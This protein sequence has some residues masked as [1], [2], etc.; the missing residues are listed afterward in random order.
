MEINVVDTSISVF[1]SIVR[2]VCSYYAISK[3]SLFSGR[4]FP[5]IVRAKFV[6]IALAKHLGNYRVGYLANKFEQDHTVV[7]N[8]IFKTET[9]ISTIFLPNSAP[10]K[11]WVKSLDERLPNVF[12]GR[13]IKKPI[14]Y[15]DHRKGRGKGNFPR[16]W[17]QERIDQLFYLKKRMFSDTEIGEKM[18]ISRETVRYNYKKYGATQ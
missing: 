5:Y 16:Q 10:L 7:R 12:I 15:I 9:A 17:P 1:E 11:E 2:E 6:V 4:K 8:A 18:G 13:A 14:L 3:G